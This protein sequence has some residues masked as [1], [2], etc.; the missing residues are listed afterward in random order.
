MSTNYDS[1]TDELINSFAG[2]E[3]IKKNFSQAYQDLFVLTVLGGK[4][5]GKYLEIGSCHPFELSNTALLES[6]G[7]K[8]ISIDISSEFVSSFN[9][10]RSEKSYQ[11][12]ATKFDW[13]DAIKKKRWKTKRIDYLSCDCEPSMT[14]YDA[15]KNIPHDEYRFSVITFETEVYK[16]GPRSR[17]MQREFLENLGYQLVCSNVCN[18]GSPFED[19]WVD[20]LV[21]PEETWKPLQCEMVEA[22]RIFVK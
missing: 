7:W 1:D 5:N 17:E 3:K 10:E 12:D 9:L 11:A 16:E 21:V 22:R 20:P 13:K 4:T 8:G 2:S 14:T 18:M 15:L 19:W 6:I